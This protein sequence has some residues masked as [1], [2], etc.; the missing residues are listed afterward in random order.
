MKKINKIEKPL[1]RLSKQRRFKLLKSEMNMRTFLYVMTT[2]LTEV[3][4]II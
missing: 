3:K 2:D 4:R 1:A